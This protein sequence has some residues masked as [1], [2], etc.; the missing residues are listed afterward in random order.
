MQDLLTLFPHPII[1]GPMAGGASTPALVAAVSNGGGLGSL[2]CGMLTPLAMIEQAEHIR[3]LSD[4][5][6]AM[7]LFVQA[8]PQPGAE[9]IA[10]AGE[11]LRPVWSQFGWDKLPLPARWCEDFEQQ[12]DALLVAKPAV[13]SFTF[14][15]I[16]AAH[17]QR[18]HAAGIA[19]IGTATQVAEALAWQQ[20]GADAVC[21]S[22]VEAGGH[23]GTFIGAQE[24]ATLTAPELLRAALPVLHIPAIAAGNIMDG[25][26]IAAALAAGAGAVQMGSAFLV[27]S[28]SGIHPAYKQALLHAAANS[29]AQTRGIT[30]RFARGLNNPFIET[31]AAVQMQVPA[32]PV[33]NALTAAIRTQAGKNND[34][35]WMSLWAGTGIHRARAL[36]AVELLALLLQE[37]QQAGGE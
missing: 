2:A 19:V 10:Q 5:P 32:Y 1:Q 6:F 30:G 37:L 15:I 21:L 33:Q 24:A 14:G 28:E 23:R 27:T 3:Q 16:D 22:G 35:A 13:A 11:L 20:L 8:T 18:L 7:N 29:T 34:T 31:M 26:D 12:F 25:K 36:P 9:E 4:R 17:L